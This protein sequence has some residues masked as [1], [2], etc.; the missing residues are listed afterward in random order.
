MGGK[1]ELPQG[2]AALEALR[3]HFVEREMEI[4]RLRH[5]S[6]S[7]GQAVQWR[8]PTEEEFGEW[9]TPLDA[10]GVSDD[11]LAAD[12]EK[13]AILEQLRGGQIIAVARTAQINPTVASVEAFV[14]VLPGPWR[15]MGQ[16]DQMY[17]WKTGHLVVSTGGTDSYGG[18][19]G[20]KQRYFN[21]RFDPASFSGRPPPPAIDELARTPVLAIPAPPS[22]PR[23]VGR[24]PMPFWED[25]LVELFDRLWHGTLTPNT[26]ADIEKAMDSWLIANEHS[27]SE[28]AV[29]DR[30]RKLWKVWTKEG[31]N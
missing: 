27:A 22:S 23:K 1:E 31:K 10:L 21:V 29:R 7:M 28:R 13:W 3:E 4:L 18:E 12:H 19:T 14:R 30:A 5:A 9:F 8:P 15:R 11:A 16:A 24:P 17:F 2:R 26:Q 20:E 6:G 25:L